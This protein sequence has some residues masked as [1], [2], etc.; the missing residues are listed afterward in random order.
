MMERGEAR[1]RLGLMLGDITT[2]P[3]DA[4][5]NAANRMLLGGG[6]VDGAIHRAAGH[7]LYLECLSPGGCDPGDAKVT[8]GHELRARQVIHT[9]GPIWE[10]GRFGEDEILASC[11]RRCLELAAEHQVGTLAFPSIS[12]GAYGFPLERAARIAVREI[13][14]FLCHHDLPKRVT[15]VCFD[16]QT[17]SAYRSALAAHP[18]STLL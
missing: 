8:G 2:V 1:S 5:V 3:S 13:L 16:P 14:A 17:L 9:V 12:T 7:G 10:G 4:L 11:Y 6:G 15:M 18:H